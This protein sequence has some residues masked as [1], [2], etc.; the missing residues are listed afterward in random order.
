MG[1]TIY[2][3]Y[4][5]STAVIPLTLSGIPQAA[6]LTVETSGTSIRWRR[7]GVDPTST[8]GQL[9]GAGTTITLVGTQQVQNFRMIRN[10]GSLDATV[11][12]TVDY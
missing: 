11:S 3:Q 9:A 2:S 6:I 8:V 4:V 1:A 12:V 10:T 7:D 5:V